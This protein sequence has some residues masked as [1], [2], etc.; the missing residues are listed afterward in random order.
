MRDEAEVTQAEVAA[1]FDQ[2]YA[3][4]GERYLRPLAA[5]P[6]FLQMLAAAPGSRLLDVA[7]GAGLLLDAAERRGLRVTGID[8]SQQALRLARK[9]TREAELL[10]ANV[11]QLPF[12]AGSFDHVTC[13]GS[14]ERFL[15]RER[16]LAEMHRVG[17]PAAQYC[18]LVR[19]ADA[20]G[21][22]VWRDWL[23]RRERQGHQDA[24]T[25]AQWSELFTR[26]GFAVAAVHADQWARQRLR[27]WLRGRPEPS[28]EQV[29]PIV[30]P[31]LGMRFAYEFVFLLRK[32]RP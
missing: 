15:D 16:A 8:L 18:F 26:C 6:I 2:T 23:G 12:A 3:T 9:R 24:L 30:R 13:L 27:W 25:R 19:N 11:E 21:W 31:W 28:P 7:C 14:L 10:L 29:E 5:Y 4:R 1:W 20:P 22:R 17:T 32:A